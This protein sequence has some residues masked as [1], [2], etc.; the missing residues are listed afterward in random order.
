REAGQSPAAQPPGPPGF[1]VPA[2]PRAYSTPEA[3]SLARTDRY[4]PAR[5]HAP[6][7]QGNSGRRAPGRNPAPR[8]RSAFPV[9]GTVPPQSAPPP[10]GTSG[11]NQAKY[12]VETES[13]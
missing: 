3:D 12:E 8:W 10:S 4:G 13:P 7:D 9:P 5:T 2:P 6:P 1:S 11:E